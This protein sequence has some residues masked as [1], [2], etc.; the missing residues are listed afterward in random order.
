[1]K[2]KLLR[3]K[4]LPVIRFGQHHAALRFLKFYLLKNVYFTLSHRLVKSINRNKNHIIELLNTENMSSLYNISKFYN[5][6]TTVLQ[7]KNNYHE[8]LKINLKMS[9]G[10]FKI[11][12]TLRRPK[13]HGPCYMGLQRPMRERFG[14]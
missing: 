7:L 13:Q 6:Y 9:L 5:N 8:S 14:C 2:K 10:I 11:I 4:T 1:M 3:Q 12:L